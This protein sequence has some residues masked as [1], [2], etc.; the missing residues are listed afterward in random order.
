LAGEILRLH[1]V[2]RRMTRRGTPPGEIL[3]PSP[4]RIDKD[5]SAGAPRYAPKA[6][7]QDDDVWVRARSCVYAPR[8]LAQDDGWVTVG[9]PLWFRDVAARG[10]AKRCDSSTAGGVEECRAVPGTSRN[11]RGAHGFL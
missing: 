1:Y 8:A 7:A 9:E 5:D 2:A 4:H 6:L 11:H 3:R 10:Y